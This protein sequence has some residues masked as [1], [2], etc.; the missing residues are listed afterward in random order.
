MSLNAIALRAGERASQ[1]AS[2]AG[3]Q[4]VSE[5]ASQ[6]VG[7]SLR[8]LLTGTLAR[9]HTHAQ[10]IG[11]CQAPRAADTRTDRRTDGQEGEASA[12]CAWFGPSWPA[13]CHSTRSVLVL[14]PFNP[15]RR[16]GKLGEIM[17][18]TAGCDNVKRRPRPGTSIG[19][20]N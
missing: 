5:P 8:R 16:L 10:S 20:P 18:A 9:A 13:G 17:T 14:A 11:R 15:K 7:Q 19:V 3:K 6:Q 2:R 4:P 1:P 12:N